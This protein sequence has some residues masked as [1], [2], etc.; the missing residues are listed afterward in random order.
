MIP[1][2]LP[3]RIRHK[4]SGP[5]MERSKS[6]STIAI[7]GSEPRIAPANATGEIAERMV[8]ESMVVSDG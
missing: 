8:P 1:F 2:S 5:G 3:V 6:H 7:P 4:T